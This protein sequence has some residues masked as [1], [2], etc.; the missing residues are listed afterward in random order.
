MSGPSFDHERALIAGGIWPVAGIDE[1][2]RGPLAGPLAAAAVILD[3]SRIPRGLNDSKVLAPRD[4]ERAYQ[5]IMQ[6]A[7]A[8]AIAFVSAAEIDAIN[9]R[10]ATFSAMRK[11][12]RAL[13]IVPRNAL[14]DGNDLPPELPVPAATIIKG[15]GIVASIAAASIVAKVSRDRMMQQ[16]CRHYPAYGFS[17]HFGYAT[18]AHLAA[19]EKHGPCPAHR[20]SFKPFARRERQQI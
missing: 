9:I 14:I 3:P 4:R 1:A 15:D 8:V 12:L 17:E 19:I 6:S 16:L 18:K 5:E 11:A 10:E 2:G 7:Q 13:A 20:L